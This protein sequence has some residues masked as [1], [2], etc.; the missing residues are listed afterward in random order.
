MRLFLPLLFL[1][2]SGLAFAQPVIVGIGGIDDEQPQ[3]A[4]RGFAAMWGAG[5]GG[6]STNTKVFVNGFEAIVP[7]AFLADDELIFQV[8]VGI[9]VGPASFTVSV[10][11]VASAP[12]SFSVS[13]FAPIIPDLGDAFHLDGSVVSVANPSVPGETVRVTLIT[14]LGAAHPPALTVSVNG[15]PVEIV[16]LNDNVEP[17]FQDGLYTMVAIVPLGLNVQGHR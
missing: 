5:F 11:G 16:S 7:E 1:L 8:P 2:C 3:V 12:F 15:F 13:M 9:E 10:S 4:P 17:F 14:G 6:P